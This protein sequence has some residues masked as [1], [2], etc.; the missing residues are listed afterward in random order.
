MDGELWVDGRK[1][2]Y[3][4]YQAGKLVRDITSS[5]GKT[6]YFVEHEGKYC[7]PSVASVDRYLLEFSEPSEASVEDGVDQETGA[8]RV[9][10]S[11][12]KTDNIEGS[13][14]PWYTEDVTYLVKDGVVIGV[15]TR[16]D[17]PNKDGSDYDLDTSRRI[18]SDLKV[19]E[20]IPPETFDLPYPIK[21]A[22]G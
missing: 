21:K 16:G 13:D 2:R 20:Q 6:A 4:L 18:F 12:K 3:S 14:N 15:I 9:V 5:D 1:F 11:V 17:T 22:D 10:Y 19:G 7:E 8:K